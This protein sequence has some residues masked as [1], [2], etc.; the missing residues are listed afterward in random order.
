MNSI[1]NKFVIQPRMLSQSALS[2][3]ISDP[4]FKATNLIN[5]ATVSSLKLSAICLLIGR[6]L[7]VFMFMSLV[8]APKLGAVA[9][10]VFATDNNSEGFPRP[11]SFLNEIQ[12]GT[13]PKRYLT[14]LE[15]KR[16]L[17][18][19][20]EIT[21]PI[22]KKDFEIDENNYV[23]VSFQSLDF[24]N[25]SKIFLLWN[26]IDQT[27]LRSNIFGKILSKTGDVIKHQFQINDPNMNAVFPKLTKLADGR[28]LIT[29]IDLST[30]MT[31]VQGKIFSSSALIVSED[32]PT[33]SFTSYAGRTPHLVISLPNK[34]YMM[35]W[36]SPSPKALYRII[37]NS[38][39]SVVK[40]EYSLV[41]DPATY[42]NFKYFLLSNGDIF[43]SWEARPNSDTVKLY[44]VTMN[45]N[46]NIISGPERIEYPY[47]QLDASFK[48]IATGELVAVWAGWKDMIQG[49]AIFLSLFDSNRIALPAVQINDVEENCLDPKVN[50]ISDNKVLVTWASYSSEGKM[51]IK[52]KIV[53]IKIS[54]S[55]SAHQT[56]IESVTSELLISQDFSVSLSI[57]NSDHRNKIYTVD[58]FNG[59]FL[60]SWI[61]SADEN[62]TNSDIMFT[63]IHKTGSILMKERKMNIQ[64]TQIQSHHILLCDDSV[65]LSWQAESK[66]WSKVFKALPTANS[67]PAIANPIPNTEIA[68]QDNFSIKLPSNIF[69]DDPNDTLTYSMDCKGLE[70]TFDP[71]TNRISGRI[72]NV[73]TY[74]INYYAQDSYDAIVGT[75]F[76]IVVK[77]KSNHRAQVGRVC[78]GIVGIA[79]L[80]FIGYVG[81]KKYKNGAWQTILRIK[82][83]ER[84]S[85]VKPRRRLS[86]L[87]LR[88][89]ELNDI[90]PVIIPEKFICPI[91]HEM[92]SEPLIVLSSADKLPHS[93]EKKAIEEWLKINKVD[94]LTRGKIKKISVNKTL[95]KEIEEYIKGLSVEELRKNRTLRKEIETWISKRGE[96]NL[97]KDKGLSS[98]IDTLEKANCNE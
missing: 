77:E 79:A 91:T 4:L 59:N 38:N 71:V 6:L 94:P 67:I 95:K 56:I 40:P 49:Y 22:I 80:I 36:S 98:I 19:R 70:I 23:I 21:L 84:I 96:E 29:W 74:S 88:D 14:S 32:T 3:P 20:K 66:I 39:N 58:K 55:H 2:C 54:D 5:K 68:P 90:T 97:L 52:G 16:T 17:L 28:V 50:L 9:K 61:K 89:L 7:F 87:N 43:V 75:S 45:Q 10:E 26:A 57:L 27:N 48:D 73:G 63:I 42:T 24:D 76:V 47:N 93:Y 65:I 30:S 33:I 83:A 31:N 1:S 72:Q 60:V 62:N 12:M 46:G 13:P 81:Y 69:V 15:H 37:I 44:G 78:G 85:P 82:R 25:E 53:Q 18:N 86:N 92:M 35:I 41:E 34:N 51:K 64:G 8:C 11:N